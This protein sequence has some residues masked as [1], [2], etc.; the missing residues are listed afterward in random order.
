MD[1]FLAKPEYEAPFNRYWQTRIGTIDKY[2]AAAREAGLLPGSVE[3]ISHRI[4]H[5]WTTTLALMQAEVHEE[6][7]SP[8]EAARH[9]SLRAHEMMRQG[10]ADESLRYALMSF[11]NGR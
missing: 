4:Q 6:K 11:S 7:S 10:L 8:P 9:A 5:F 3:D 2:L 1:C